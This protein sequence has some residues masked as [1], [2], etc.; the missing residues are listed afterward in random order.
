MGSGR[1]W[2][3][4]C[5]TSSYTELDEASTLCKHLALVPVWVTET[6]SC[7]M[8]PGSGAKAVSHSQLPDN[9]QGVYML[10]YKMLLLFSE[11]SLHSKPVQGQSYNKRLLKAKQM[12][13]EHT[14]L[15]WSTPKL[16]L[17]LGFVVV[18]GFHTTTLLLLH[19][20][21]KLCLQSLLGSRVRKQHSYSPASFMQQLSDQS[22][23]TDVTRLLCSLQLNP[24]A[25]GVRWQGCSVP[26]LGTSGDTN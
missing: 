5:T 1:S 18:S 19:P 23:S 10:Q 20:E 13:R 7:Q 24:S 21:L 11:T 26:L 2:A 3:H 8:S 22:H 16:L 4:P 25:T 12:T 14:I 9:C 15:C 17:L 6:A